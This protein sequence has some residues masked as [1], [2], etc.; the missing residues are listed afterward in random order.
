[1]RKKLFAVIDQRSINDTTK[2]NQLTD[3][4]FKP[5]DSELMIEVTP[6][7]IDYSPVSEEVRQLFPTI[8]RAF[9]SRLII[10]L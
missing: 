8:N 6:V 3:G 1:M 7:G 5:G 4:L 9:V 10:Q 2:Y